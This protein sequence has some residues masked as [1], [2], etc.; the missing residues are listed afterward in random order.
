M[1]L[2]LVDSIPQSRAIVEA[3]AH[4]AVARIFGRY[5]Y[6]VDDPALTPEQIRNTIKRMTADEATCVIGAFGVVIKLNGGFNVAP[7]DIPEEQKYKKLQE[8]AYHY[9]NHPED[10]PEPLKRAN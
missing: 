10:L 5:G 9:R 2:T 3:R 7:P 1:S 8:M 6:D 4:A